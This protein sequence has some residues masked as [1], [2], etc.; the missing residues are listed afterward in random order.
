MTDSLDGLRIPS[1]AQG[2][3][4]KYSA[5]QVR[6]LTWTRVVELDSLE[7][8]K[9]TPEDSAECT[10]LAGRQI[11]ENGTQKTLLLARAN[12]VLDLL[13]RKNP[14]ILSPQPKAL[15]IWRMS[16]LIVIVAFLLGMLTDELSTTNNR[17]N[18]LAPPL[19]AL[20][21]WNVLVYLWLIVSFVLGLVK[22]EPGPSKGPIRRFAGY[23]LLKLQTWGMKKSPALTK[24]YEI[25]IPAERGILWRMAA[26]TLHLGAMCL[27]LGLIASIAVRGW[28]TSYTAG[29]ESTWLANSPEIVLKFLNFVYGSIPGSSSLFQSLDPEMI[30]RMRFDVAPQGVPATEWMVCLITATA[31]IVILPRFLLFLWNKLRADA[32]QRNF[33]INLQTP[34][35][36]NI[37]RQWHG[38]SMTIH[39]LPFGKSLSEAEKNGIKELSF[40]VNQLGSRFVFDA[41]AHE[42]TPLPNLSGD[43]AEEAWIVFQMSS[44]PEQEVHIRYAEEVKK[45]CA[46]ADAGC[47]IIVDSGNF[48]GR[49]SKLQNRI[50]ERRKNWSSFLGK[51][52][53]PYAFVDLTNV[54]AKQAEAEFE[55][56]AGRD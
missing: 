12:L 25:W 24:F 26:G 29:W 32:I 53:I 3:P 14:S 18:L 16:I 51:T 49:F 23:W 28:G 41:V 34:Y 45:A 21:L 5:D 38:K 9:I 47:R 40:V 37:I 10:K 56:T 52:K 44:T 17:I 46:K 33:P 39:V 42:D 54:D 35:Y 19:L 30:R 1:G 13:K 8:K 22:R 11:G 50:G 55:Q 4:N 2:N 31:I 27:G 20:Y 15:G 6:A 36:Q 48:I 7:N 43:D